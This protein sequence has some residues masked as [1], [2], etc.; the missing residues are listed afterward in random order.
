[1]NF[2]S[3]PFRTADRASIAQGVREFDEICKKS[4]RIWP[5]GRVQG[6]TVGNRQV[7]LLIGNVHYLEEITMSR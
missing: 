1:M 7:Y 3:R 2:L 5:D 4:R 6:L